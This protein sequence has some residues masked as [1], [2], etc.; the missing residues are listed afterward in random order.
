MESENR[1]TLF[2]L[3]KPVFEKIKIVPRCL[4]FQ[5]FYGLAQVHLHELAAVK[6]S[7]KRDPEWSQFSEEYVCY[8]TKD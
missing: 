2:E 4:I 8:Q 7:E 5:K 6:E 3:I 1:P